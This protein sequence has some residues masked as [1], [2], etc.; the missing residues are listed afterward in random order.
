MVSAVTTPTAPALV[1]GA[2]GWLGSRL[3]RSLVHG[4]PDVPEL[5]APGERAVRCLVRPGESREHLG[6]D[7]VL[8]GDVTRPG[9]LEPIFR[10][11]SGGTVFHCA[12]LIHPALRVRDLYA[13]N[14]D[15]TRH[16]LEAARRA[17]VRR[18]IHVSSNSPLGCNPGRYHLFDEYSSY[19]PYMSYGKSKMQGELVVKE[20]ANDLEVVIIRAPWF[21]GPHQPARQTLFFRMIRDGKV[22]LVGDGENRRSMA[23]VDNLCHGLMLAERREKAAGR[24]YWISDRRPY[25]MNEIVGTIARLLEKEFGMTVKHGAIRLP[26]ITGQIAQVVD[27]SLQAIGLYHQKIHVLSE[28]NKDIAGSIELAE[29][30]LGYTPAIELEEGMRRSLRWMLDRGMSLDG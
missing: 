17:G 13:V 25:T 4:L 30:E 24:T 16:V 6:G 26:W 9:T 20:F 1:T 2:A 23:Y 12:G 7:E 15:G 14:V 19:N 5:A 11:M 22:P 10:G 29:K 18:V 27:F 3:A 21:Y 8:E 28:M